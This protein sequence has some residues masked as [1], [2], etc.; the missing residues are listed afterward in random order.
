[1]TPDREAKQ[2][3]LEQICPSCQKPVG[4]QVRVFY[5]KKADTKSYMCERCWQSM[6]E[7]EQSE[8]M[9]V[10]DATELIDSD[11]MNKP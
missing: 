4:K 6:T 11:E 7:E 10:W 8:L 5:Y 3:L 2:W 9:S 1:M